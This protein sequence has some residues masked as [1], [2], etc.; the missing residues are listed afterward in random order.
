MDPVTYEAVIAFLA[1]DAVATKLALCAKVTNEAVCAVVTNEAVC[2]V[3]TNEAV[4]AS[5][6]NEAVTEFCAQLEVPN[7]EP[8]KLFIVAGP[9]T[10]KLPVMLTDPVN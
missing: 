3:V 2:A 6:T 8:V 9:T 4:C 5:V 7:R 1:H 10:L